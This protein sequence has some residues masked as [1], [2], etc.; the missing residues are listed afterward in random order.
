MTMLRCISPI[1]GS[2]YAERP[3]MCLDEAQAA[4]ARA[5]ERSAM[6]GAALAERIALVR[7]GVAKLGQMNDV[8]VPELARMMGRPVRYGGEFRGVEERASYMAEIA[9]QALA[10]LRIEDSK[11]FTALDRA[12]A[13]RRDPGHR[14]LELP[15]PHRDQQRGAGPD[16][17][18]CGDPQARDPDAARGRADGRGVRRRRRAGGRV[19]G[20][21]P[22]PC[23]HRAADRSAR[24]R[25][26][27]LH[28]LGRGRARDRAGGGR[29]ASPASGWSSAA[30]TR[31]MSWTMRTWTPRPTR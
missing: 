26:R 31:A 12:R 5:R 21:V 13:A 17:R 19:P 15:L 2:V 18:Q 24:V 29:H 16:R 9:E 14:T 27:E 20:R 11:K 30:R 4:I 6:G 22:R 10:P 3:A 7:D 23:D 25:L 1:D 8:I 28:R